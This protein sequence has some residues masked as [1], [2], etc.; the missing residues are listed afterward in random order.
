LTIQLYSPQEGRAF[1]YDC[2]VKSEANKAEFFNEKNAVLDENGNWRWVTKQ[3]EVIA[4]FD[5]TN[6][7]KNFNDFVDGIKSFYE[8]RG[9]KYNPVGANCQHFVLDIVQ[10]VLSYENGKGIIKEYTKK[11]NDLQAQLESREYEHIKYIEENKEDI[12][13]DDNNN[14]NHKSD[15]VDSDV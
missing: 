11:F 2:S 9:K 1:I 3:C 10:S 8:V 13:E 12:K 15:N 5:L 4:D 7:S 6:Q 14:E